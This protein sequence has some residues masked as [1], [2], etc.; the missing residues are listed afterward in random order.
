MMTILEHAIT[1]N[2]ITEILSMIGRSRMV[3]TYFVLIKSSFVRL[4][5]AQKP[6]F[7]HPILIGWLNTYTRLGVLT[8]DRINIFIPIQSEVRAFFN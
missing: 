6:F 1:E 8:K 5:V 7:H 3:I 4:L 2:L